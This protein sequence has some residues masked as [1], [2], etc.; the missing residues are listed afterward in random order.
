MCITKVYTLSQSAIQLYT[1]HSQLT[2]KLANP[3]DSR[4][5]LHSTVPARRLSVSN[6][7][8]LPRT[9]PA[10]YMQRCTAVSAV[11]LQ[12]VWCQVELKL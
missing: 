1:F 10:T 7:V 3:P 2:E 12:H 5:R 9:R 11:Q 8:S 6:S 4:Q